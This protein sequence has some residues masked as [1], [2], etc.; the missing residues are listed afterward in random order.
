MERSIRTQF[1]ALAMLA[2]PCLV[3]AALSVGCSSRERVTPPDDLTPRQLVDRGWTAFQRGDF[4]NALADFTQAT[5]DSA[6]FGDAFVGLGW[7]RLNRAGSAS[8]EA[9]AVTAFDT[10]LNLGANVAETRSGRAAANLGAGTS[11]YASAITDAQ[12]ARTANPSFVFAHRTS[13]EAKDLLLEE[14]FALAGQGQLQNAIGI[15]DQ[16]ATSGIQAGNQATWTV[17]GTTY[18]S[19]PTAVLGYLQKLS[20]QHA[21]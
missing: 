14:A 1:Q 17:D 7:T 20:N 2:M 3:A 9:A 16:I 12:A 19:F 10:A 4:D 13:F 21:G 18:P 15:A 6:S 8:D 11:G 5:Q